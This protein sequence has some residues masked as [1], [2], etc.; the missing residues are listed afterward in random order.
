V[1]LV[2]LSGCATQLPT[3]LLP[4]QDGTISAVT[5]ARDASAATAAS[6]DKATEYCRK[7]KGVAVFLEEDVEYQGVLTEGGA[8]TVRNVPYV[9]KALTSDED[10]QVTAKFRCQKAE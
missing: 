10:F 7:Q 8:R 1:F 2:G 3:L 4:R 9:G 5:V 6:V